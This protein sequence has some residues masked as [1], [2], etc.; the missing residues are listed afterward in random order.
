MAKSKYIPL[1]LEKL[2][3]GPLSLRTLK[4]ECGQG[5]TINNLRKPLHRLLLEGKIEIKGYD[6]GCKTFNIDC[7]MI[8]KVDTQ[9]NNPIYVKGLLDKPLESDNYSQIQTIF[10][11][12]I[13]KINQIY[14]SE[15]KELKDIQGTMPLKDAIK[16]EYIKPDDV[17]EKFPDQKDITFGD[18]LEEYPNAEAW[19][20][21]KDFQSKIGIIHTSI[22]DGKNYPYFGGIR[23]KRINYDGNYGEKRSFVDSYENYLSHLPIDKFAEQSLFTHFVIGVLKE[24]GEDR[25][26][27]MWALAS[28]LTEIDL[29][30]FV[31]KLRVI[32][33][34]FPLIF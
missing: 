17:Y 23:G 20:L 3:S 10:N 32:S 34:E 25:E 6:E 5:N 30:L 29:T 33:P 12:R 27:R 24:K 8:K 1:I 21:K 14:H 4:Q 9:F 31:D 28:D 13:E 15:I 26:D 7:I 19:Y 11:K 18:I 16:L 2:D 22:L